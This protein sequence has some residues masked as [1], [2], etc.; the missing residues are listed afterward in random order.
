MTR[1]EPRLLGTRGPFNRDHFFLAFFCQTRENGDLTRSHPQNLVV[2]TRPSSRIYPGCNNLPR[3]PS[4]PC[5][6][7]TAYRPKICPNHGVL[8]FAA[9]SRASR[10]RSDASTVVS[11]LVT[12]AAA[13]PSGG[14]SKPGRLLRSGRWAKRSAIYP[15]LKAYGT[16]G[17]TIALPAVV[18]L[19]AAPKQI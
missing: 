1:H 18:R 12:S 5:L 17:P 10:A 6:E 16:V 11:S 3:D 8:G 7:I 19:L 4:I 15:P 9:H 2:K 14:P 13:E